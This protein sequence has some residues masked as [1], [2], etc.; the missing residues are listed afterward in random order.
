MISFEL[1]C[2]CCGKRL[3]KVHA[4]NGDGGPFHINPAD[5]QPCAEKFLEMYP[6]LGCSVEI[7]VADM[8]KNRA[9]AQ[10][11]HL[12]ERSEHQ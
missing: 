1:H 8:Q 12:I 9:M 2:G 5:D 3:I 10:A 4:E 11:A 7:Q 6:N